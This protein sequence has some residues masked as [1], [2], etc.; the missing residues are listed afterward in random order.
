MTRAIYIVAMMLFFTGNMFAQN[1]NVGISNDGSSPNSKAILDVSSTTK[2]F[3]PPR[4]TFAQ[5]NA[6]TDPPVGLMLYCSNCGP[7]GVLQIFNG[8]DWVSITG[9]PSGLPGAP[10]IGTA[11]P[12]NTQAFV[13]FTAPVNTGG[14]ITSYTAT[15]SPGGFTGTLNQAGSGTITVNGLTNGTAYTFAV[16]ATNATGTSEA[17]SASNS[18]TPV[19]IGQSY[20]GGI[21]FYVDG[22]GH[23]L[24]AATEDQ[25]TLYGFTVNWAVVT[26]Q[27]T[28]VPLGTGTTIGTGSANTDHII[29][30]NGA[31]NTYAA[32]LARSYNGGG[33]SDWFLPS[34]DELF[35]M[36]TQK[37]AIGSFAS[38]SYWSSSEYNNSSAWYQVFLDGMQNYKNKS[39]VFRVRAIRAF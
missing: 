22:T 31:G 17:S 21:V 26:Y 39:F 30:Q 33:Y 15:S 36:Y 28:S 12:G 23:G 35:L 20:G 6:I 4:M 18:M 7:E 2:G 38:E 37:V 19:G 24:I 13:S 32:G 10:T 25:H 14:T 1:G 27:S 5:R 8:T 16:T 34:K 11:L 3:L 29:A 9:A